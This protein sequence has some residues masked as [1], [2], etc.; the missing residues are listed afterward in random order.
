MVTV[1]GGGWGNPYYFNW[2]INPHGDI[3]HDPDNLFVRCYFRIN[4]NYDVIYPDKH[5]FS[6]S[7]SGVMGDSKH[8][9]SIAPPA[10]EIF[11][12]YETPYVIQIN[13]YGNGSFQAKVVMEKERWYRY[14]IHVQKINADKEKWHIRLDG[15]DITDKFYC[16]GQ[17]EP[18]LYGKWLTDLYV[19][20]WG[21][22]NEYHGNLWLSTYDMETLNDGWDVAAVEVRDDRWPGPVEGAA[23]TY[24]PY[25]SGL[26]P[27]PGAT[28]VPV[29]SSVSAH[30]RDDGDGVNQSS[31]VM[32]VNGQTVTPTITGS[33]ADY[34]V[35]YN[36]AVPFGNGQT[37]NVSIDARDLHV[38]ANVMPTYSYSFTTIASS[39]T[40]PPQFS[41]VNITPSTLG[42]NPGYNTATIKF[43]ASETLQANPTVKVGPYSAGF[44][45][46][47]GNNYTYTYVATGNESPENTPIG[48]TISG[49]DLAGNVGQTT[50]GSVMFDF[51]VLKPVAPQP[52]GPGA[53][54]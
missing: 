45:N 19:Q 50:S 49:T 13:N 23:D 44:S 22:R 53:G 43:T 54:T 20:G 34:T 35:T 37:V 42:K 33:A 3:F 32:K 18:G 4:A 29:N 31:I 46:K 9:L 48:V 17:D 24:P 41:S 6:G 30:V 1:G 47:S 25:T 27:A 14:E 39:D 2:E 15:V 40:T 8:Y 28:N 38:P 51:S 5:W 36:H 11:H 12:S 52:L 7:D 21:F 16:I 10:S 26:S